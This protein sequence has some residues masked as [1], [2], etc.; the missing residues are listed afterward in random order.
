MVGDTVP[1][2]RRRDLRGALGV[3]QRLRRLGVPGRA[4]GDITR[5][6]ELVTQGRGG[7][8]GGET[9]AGRDDLLVKVG[10]PRRGTGLALECRLSARQLGRQIAGAI[11]ALADACQLG[12]GAAAAAARQG[13]AGRLLDHGAEVR[14]AG[15]ADG[16]HLTLPDHRQRIG[17]ESES[18]QRF[19]DIQ[20][21]TRGAVELVGRV[22]ARVRRRATSVSAGWSCSGCAELTVMRTSAR[23]AGGR[24][25]P[26]ENTTSAMPDARS[27]VARCSPIDQTIAS[28]RLLLPDP[29][30]RRSHHAR[31]ELQ[32]DGRGERLEAAQMNPSQHQAWSGH[33]R[34][35]RGC[36]GPLR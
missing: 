19:V 27:R 20:E 29:L 15:G 1:Q 34:E 18:P 8:I 32:V 12:L 36:R 30:D 4:A 5:R 22:T 16:L 2:G 28:A 7:L 33:Q 26:P 24:P 23:P 25:S 14:R 35:H 10:R 31:A 21:A 17:A 11:Q 13:H 3:G 9:P 6:D